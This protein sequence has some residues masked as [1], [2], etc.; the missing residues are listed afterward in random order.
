M[1]AD[2]RCYLTADKLVLLIRTQ[3]NECKSSLS[4]RVANIRFVL[5]SEWQ[6]RIPTCTLTRSGA[7]GLP[8]TGGL[9]TPRKES[10]S[11]SFSGDGHRYYLARP[12]LRFH[13]VLIGGLLLI[14][15]SS[16]SQRPSRMSRGAGLPRPVGDL[17]FGHRRL[18]LSALTAQCPEQVA[19]STQSAGHW[20]RAEPSSG[21]GHRPAVG[22]RS[23]RRDGRGKNRNLLCSPAPSYREEW[24][25]SSQPAFC[26]GYWV[27]MVFVCAEVVHLF[28]LL[29]GPF[30]E[31]DEFFMMNRNEEVLMDPQ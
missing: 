2:I 1:I 22:K 5:L 17:L 8:L 20:S 15:R 3:L 14:S 9:E 19:K 29:T 11:K 23:Q 21:R 12:P 30:L 18:R 31:I 7:G 25:A 27:N 4:S 10:V 28:I 6:P 13:R 16:L 26:S 24:S